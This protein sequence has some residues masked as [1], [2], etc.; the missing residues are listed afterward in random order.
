MTFVY[1]TPFPFKGQ[2]VWQDDEDSILVNDFIEYEDYY[3]ESEDCFYNDDE[4]ENSE[5]TYDF[6]EDE[7]SYDSQYIEESL[8]SE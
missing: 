5:I 2:S 8:D 6:E 1:F 7:E 4:E 3:S